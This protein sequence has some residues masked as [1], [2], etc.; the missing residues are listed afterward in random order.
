M[1]FTGF[2]AVELYR[3]REAEHDD[4]ARRTSWLRELR[5]LDRQERANRKRPNLFKASARP[6]SPRT[7]T[8]AH[9]PWI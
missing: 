7:L 6:Q 5:D 1:D 9:N 8:G 4:H 2:A 3:A